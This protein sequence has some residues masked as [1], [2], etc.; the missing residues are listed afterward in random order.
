M[1]APVDEEGRVMSAAAE[2]HRNKLL[3]E[4]QKKDNSPAVNEFFAGSSFKGE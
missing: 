4:R 2:D 3:W 1:E